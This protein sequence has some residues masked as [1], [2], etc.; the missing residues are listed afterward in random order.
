MRR[1]IWSISSS[2]TPANCFVDRGLRVGPRSFV[3]R[4]VG[5]P[6]EAAQ[7]GEVPVGDPDRVL[8]ERHLQLTAEVLTRRHRELGLRPVCVLH[9]RVVAHVHE[10]RQPSGP[11][12]DH[13]H[14]Q[15]GELREHPARREMRRGLHDRSLHHRVVGDRTARTAVLH[16]IAADTDVERERHAHLT[17]GLPHRI[18]L[19]IVQRQ[20]VA[21][22]G[23]QCRS[24]AHRLGTSD[25]RRGG[26]DVLFRGLLPA[27]RAVALD[28]E[29]EAHRRREPPEVVAVDL[30]RPVVRALHLP[31]ALGEV[32]VGN[33]GEAVDHFGDHAVEVS[34][35][36][37][38]LGMDL[39]VLLERVL[40]DADADPRGRALTLDRAITARGDLFHLAE[41]R[42]AM[43]VRRHQ[44]ASHRHPHS[45]SRLWV[46]VFQPGVTAL[47]RARAV[48]RS[49]RACTRAR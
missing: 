1:T 46:S 4:V 42:A 5:A 34:F 40:E 19:G 22:V 20:R 11:A 7:T 13:D 39:R 15:L 6:H 37:A 26:G 41:R 47:R 9:V 25:L 38:I 29:R 24:Q 43:R 21:V 32:A 17:R 36:D 16:R 35:A 3:M 18:P 28:R 31:D 2:G 27:T 23:Q 10:P 44:H 12:L 30:G 49:R 45:R 14:L 8:L 33:A 48:R